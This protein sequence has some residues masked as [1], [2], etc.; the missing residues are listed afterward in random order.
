M[1]AL[2]EIGQKWKDFGHP[3][4]IPDPLDKNSVI[5]GFGLW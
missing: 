3:L 5:V 1:P 4:R 2:D